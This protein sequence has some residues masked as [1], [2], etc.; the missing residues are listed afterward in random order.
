MVDFKQIRELIKLGEKTE[1]KIIG[2]IKQ[3]HT[4]YS[5][6]YKSLIYMNNNPKYHTLFQR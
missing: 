3:N 1:N 2:V 4:L 5:H 6:T